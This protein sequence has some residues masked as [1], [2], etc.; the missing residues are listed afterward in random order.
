MANIDQNQEV[1]K[2]DY[3]DSYSGNNEE[4]GGGFDLK[5]IWYLILRYKYFLLISIA[6]CMAIAYAYLKYNTVEV[7]YTYSKMLIKIS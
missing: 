3:N 2:K 1:Q 7:Y 4:Q 5:V 6:V